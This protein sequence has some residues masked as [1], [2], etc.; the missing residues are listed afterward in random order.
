MTTPV[1]FIAI[2]IAVPAAISTLCFFVGDR[3]AE[4]QITPL[5]GL[6][7]AFVLAGIIFGEDRLVGFGLMGVGVILAVADILNQSSSAGRQRFDGIR[8]PLSPV[9]GIW[10]SRLW[11]QTDL[12]DRLPVSVFRQS[13]AEFTRQA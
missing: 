9:E 10:W 8:Y 7:F 13:E 12:E 5:A 11:V 1:V 4:R 2:C 3:H 6:A